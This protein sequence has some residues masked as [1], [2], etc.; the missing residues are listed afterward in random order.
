MANHRSPKPELRVRFLPPP[1]YKKKR[2]MSAL[3][4]YLIKQGHLKTKAIIKAFR[5]VKRRDFIPEEFKDSAE[6]DSPL[7]IGHGQTISQP[8]VVA[9]MLELL[10]PNSGEKILDIG[11]G[12]GWT[13]SLLA[14]IVGEKGKIVAIEIIPE[15]VEFGRKNISRY[16]FTNKGIVKIV[17]GDGSIGLAEEAPFDKIL[18]SASAKELPLAWKQQLKATNRAD[19]QKQIIKRGNYENCSYINGWFAERTNG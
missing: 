2:E 18:A 4:D 17:C 11:S 14:Q 3:I 19:K 12:S 1:Q 10:Q 7:S 5:I 15:L 16:N 13:S 9:F 6:L 8:L